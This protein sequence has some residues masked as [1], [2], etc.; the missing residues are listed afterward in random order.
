SNQVSVLYCEGQFFVGSA[1]NGSVGSGPDD[2]SPLWFCFCSRKPES[3]KVHI[4]G[5]MRMMMMVSSSSTEKMKKKPP[6]DS[7]TLLPCFYFVEREEEEEPEL[8]LDG[9]L[10]RYTS[11]LTS[12]LLP[13]EDGMEM[14]V[15]EEEEEKEEEKD[16]DRSG[17]LKH[18]A[19][20]T[21]LPDARDSEADSDLTL[22]DTDTESVPPSSSLAPGSGALCDDQERSFLGDMGFFM[23]QCVPHLYRVEVWPED[24]QSLGLSIVGGRHVIK[25]LKNGEELKGIFIKQVLP[26]SPAAKTHCLKTGDKILEVSGVDLRAASHNEAVSAIK[27][28][29]SPVVFIVQSLS[30]TPRNGLSC[31]AGFCSMAIGPSPANVSLEPADGTI[32][33]DCANVINSFQL[34]QTQSQAD[35]DRA[36]GKAHSL[37][38]TH[39]QRGQQGAALSELTVISEF[40][41]TGG[42]FSAQQMGQSFTSDS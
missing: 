38:E 36:S 10:P 2:A 39:P 1:L 5:W 28:A 3:Q 21:G 27:S 8:I 6:K 26:N 41:S 40:S 25:R 12:D 7:L 9:G 30:A 13:V 17:A 37:I 15:D 42:L 23:F 19:V 31:T 20:S 4:L 24:G 18:V 11:S 35:R 22:T 34:Q 33:G 29:P 16:E 32:R 14:A